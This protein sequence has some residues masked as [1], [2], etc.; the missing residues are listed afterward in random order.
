MLFEK[1]NTYKI[2]FTEEEIEYL[3]T[4]VSEEMNRLDNAGGYFEFLRSIKF[5]INKRHEEDI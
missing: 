2:E 5:F 1:I 3:D 4:L